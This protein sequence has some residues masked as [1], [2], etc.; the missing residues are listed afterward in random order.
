[1]ALVSLGEG[2]PEIRYYEKYPI[3]GFKAAVSAEGFF[4]AVAGYLAPVAAKS[5][6]IGFCFSNP[7]EILPNRDA[8]ILKFTKEVK[9]T[10]VGGTILGDAL[11]D[12]LRNRG[13]PSDKS[14]V[15][16]N[17]TVATQLGAMADAA[18]RG[19]YGNFIGLILGTGINASYAE[20]NENI[21]KN[22]DIAAAPGFTLINIEAGGYRGFPM[23]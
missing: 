1:M 4:D 21:L 6:K 18:E 20:R 7:A 14:V 16:L 17:D 3:P 10:G 9:V 23:S 22:P 19:K 5:G 2:P 12:A 8:R 15:V 13:L 11:R